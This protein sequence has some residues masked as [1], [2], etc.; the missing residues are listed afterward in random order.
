MCCVAWFQEEE[1]AHRERERE[2]EASKKAMEKMSGA[3]SAERERRCDRARWT[4]RRKADREK[5]KEM[6]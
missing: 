6:R 5:K 3:E 2:R 1:A 4:R